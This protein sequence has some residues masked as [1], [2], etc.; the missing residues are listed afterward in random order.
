CIEEPQGRV[1]GSQ[2]RCIDASGAR[3]PL[4]PT[5]VG[6]LRAGAA[7]PARYLT[8]DH[9]RRS[10][11]V[12]KIM[13]AVALLLVGL[14]VTGVAEAGHRTRKHS[15][16]KSHKKWHRSRQGWKRHNNW[17]RNKTGHYNRPGSRVKTGPGKKGFVPRNLI[18]PR[19]NL[20]LFANPGR[21]FAR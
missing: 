17:R 13:L 1:R 6:G 10:I 14:T 11:E 19:G 16:G 7:R 8:E 9:Q 3:L 5:G 18:A 21:S 2:E 4:L 12:K 15:T 20:P